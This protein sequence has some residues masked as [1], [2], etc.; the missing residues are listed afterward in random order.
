LL[1]VANQL[2]SSELTSAVKL[3]VPE[4]WAPEAAV[5]VKVADFKSRV[6]EVATSS[7]LKPE[8]VTSVN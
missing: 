7:T 5:N 8:E 2:G 3:A 1:V 6:V 4:I